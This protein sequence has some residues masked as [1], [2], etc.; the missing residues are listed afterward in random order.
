MGFRNDEVF[1]TESGDLGIVLRFRGVDYESLD[2]AAQKY[3]V[4]RL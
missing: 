3:A 4:K 2:L 1:L